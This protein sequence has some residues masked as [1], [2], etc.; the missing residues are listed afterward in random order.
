MLVVAMQLFNLYGRS[1]HP[2]S[3]AIEITIQTKT[4]TSTI[5]IIIFNKIANNKTKQKK[6]T[7]KKWKTTAEIPSHSAPI[8]TPLRRYS[9]GPNICWIRPKAGLENGKRH[10]NNA[11]S[12]TFKR[13]KRLACLDRRTRTAIQP[14][15]RPSNNAA[16]SVS[17]TTA[18]RRMSKM[19]AMTTT[20]PQKSL[21][22]KD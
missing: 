7:G 2:S 15:I 14:F 17:T 20:K 3:W 6:C 19:T 8:W 1:V 13:P 18:T 9:D 16:T 10:F 12:Q 21:C 4:S 22:L 5:I 11:V